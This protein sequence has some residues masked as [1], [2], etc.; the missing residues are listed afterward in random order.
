MLDQAGITEIFSIYHYLHL[1]RA[2]N[3]EGDVNYEQYSGAASSIGIKE[4]LNLYK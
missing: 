1:H 3:E 4:F 2:A